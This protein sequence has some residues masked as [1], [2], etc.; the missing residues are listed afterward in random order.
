MP[1]L[2]CFLD[3]LTHWFTQLFIDILSNDWFVNYLFKC[4]LISWFIDSEFKYL[5]IHGRKP[6]RRKEN[7]SS[8]YPWQYMAAFLLLWRPTKI[9]IY[10]QT[11]QLFHLGQVPKLAANA[12]NESSLILQAGRFLFFHFAKFEM[13]FE[14]GRK[15]KDP[16][17]QYRLPSTFA[18]FRIF[19]A[20]RIGVSN[21]EMQRVETKRPGWTVVA[22][23]NLKEE[24]HVGLRSRKITRSLSPLV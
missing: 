8:C 3:L 13:S 17:D 16:M 6:S 2:Y 10:F 20:C 9:F 24:V 21:W 22:R 18:S 1:L 14:S 4:S 15:L 23:W 7:C 11:F 12:L 5:F 19:P